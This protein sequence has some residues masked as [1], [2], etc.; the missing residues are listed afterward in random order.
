MAF[1]HWL[2]LR[3]RKGLPGAQARQCCARLDRHHSPWQTEICRLV[4]GTRIV[5]ALVFVVGQYQTCEALKA[6]EV[7]AAAV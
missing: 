3:G 4:Y 6:R 1:R 5:Y 7:D 2:G